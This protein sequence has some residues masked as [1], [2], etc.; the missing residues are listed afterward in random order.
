MQENIELNHITLVEND[1]G[2]GYYL[3]HHAVM[4]ESSTTTKLRV[5][6]DGSV[7]TTSGLSL[8][9]CCLV[10]PTLQP[11]LFDTF[12]KWRTNKIALNADVEKMYR[13]ILVD[14]AHRK[15]QKIV[16]RFSPNE[17][18]QTYQLNTVTYGTSPAPF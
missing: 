12:M 7:K 17:P 2:S 9:D 16:W 18:I 8:N 10:G 6:F 3:P 13:Q 5:V 15:Y 1:D 4:R 14:N 11:D